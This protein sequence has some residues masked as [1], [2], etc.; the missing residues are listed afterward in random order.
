ML[1]MLGG[2]P[3]RQFVILGLSLMNLDGLEAHEPIIVKGES[4]GINI[5]IIIQTGDTFQA[6]ATKDGR[7]VFIISLGQTEIKTLREYLGRT[8]IKYLA[9]TYHI[10][11]DIII[12][13]GQDEVTMQ[14]QFAEL[15]G[16]QTR[17]DI[18]RR[19]KH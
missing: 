19:H 15:V 18:D 10:P 14:H 16:P 6:T 13:S 3:P 9:V 1:R 11:V 8:I 12:V 2:Q 17:V 4:L 5:D 7:D